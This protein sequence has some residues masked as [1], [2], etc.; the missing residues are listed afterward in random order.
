MKQILFSDKTCY[1]GSIKNIGLLKSII[2]FLGSWE[3]KRLEFL[4]LGRLNKN[5]KIVCFGIDDLNN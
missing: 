3:A 2:E 1:N 5:R 4:K